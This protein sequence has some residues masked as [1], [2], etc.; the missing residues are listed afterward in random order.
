MPVPAG[1]MYY[2]ILQLRRIGKV[3]WKNDHELCT[4]IEVWTE[5]GEVLVQY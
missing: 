5:R 4:V 1:P 2:E 3:V